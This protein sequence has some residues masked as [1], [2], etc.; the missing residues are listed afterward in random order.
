MKRFKLIAL[1]VCA[2]GIC[3]AFSMQKKLDGSLTTTGWS[4]YPGQ[5]PWCYQM[6]LDLGFVCDTGAYGQLCTIG[7]GGSPAYGAE[8]GCEYAI[9]TNL[10]YRVY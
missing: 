1:L 3:S 6:N 2:I 5:G 8:F 9:S 10:L 4:L 7:G